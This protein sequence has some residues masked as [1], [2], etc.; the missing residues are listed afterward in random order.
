MK[1]KLLSALLMSAFAG[2]ATTASAGVIQAS[3]KNFAAEAF[4]ADISMVAPTIGYSLA[5]PLTGT[6][7]NPNSF[8]VTY[9][10]TAGEWDAADKPGATLVSTNNADFL[11]AAAGVI[12]PTDKRK[13]TF[14]FT[15]NNGVTFPTGST[16]VLGTN[17]VA[18]SVN[19]P[20]GGP[21][22]VVADEVTQGN[23]K[24]KKVYT[25]L[26]VPALT[27]NY[28]NPT[29]AEIGVSIK[30]TNAAGV[31]F[32][33]NFSSAPLKND[34]PILQSGVATKSVITPSSAFATAATRESS[35]VDVLVGSLGML[36]TA[37]EEGVADV[38]D[39][40]APV[41]QVLN[42]GSVEIA[43]RAALYD[44]D[45]VKI[46]GVATGFDATDVAADGKISQ[47]GLT[48]KLAGNFVAGGLVTLNSAANCAAGTDLDTAAN[49]TTF[50]AG[51][52]EATIAIDAAHLAN[53]KKVYVCYTVPGDAVI[54]V[55]QFAVT[56]GTLA[57]GTASKELATPICPAN[58][59]NLTANGVRVDVRNYIPAI[60]EAP[61]GGWKNVIRVINT[62]ES[63]PSVDVYGTALLRS[64]KL[65]ATAVI[66]AGMK[67]REVR[68]LSGATIDAKLNAA[69]T[70]AKP[71]FGADDI[72][73]NARLRITAA[74]SS[75]RVQ[76]YHFNPATGN[77]LEASAAQGDEGP[78]YVRA[79]DRDNK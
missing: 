6:A 1:Q 14:S 24:I 31:E 76:N 18:G 74:A 21:P 32:D 33:S 23:G 5:L 28:C 58:M 68:Y 54:P 72:D 55:S 29:T 49:T 13:I 22:A 53:N 78:D 36:F 75:I 44:T 61:S 50:N 59:Y 45:G 40:T 71:T 27:A 65:G 3:Y 10:L 35:R 60:V 19:Q 41:K 12:D 69:A 15:L 52:T 38:T 43:D 4:G 64:G 42:V 57:R 39:A 9:T 30:L 79:R 11:D 62:D 48:F 26:Q 63:Q 51:L 37:S 7:S 34:T 67:P 16:I 8:V 70:A 56:S 2:V 66:A 77:Y 20:V 25:T 46:Y 17:N 73:A 47:N